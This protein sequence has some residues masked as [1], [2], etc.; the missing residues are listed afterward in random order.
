MISLFTLAV[1]E[2]GEADEL[3]N[4]EE[5]IDINEEEGIAHGF[6]AT[7]R[8]EWVVVYVQHVDKDRDLLAYLAFPDVAE[9]AN[10]EIYLLPRN[11][12]RFLLKLH[13]LIAHAERSIH[14]AMTYWYGDRALELAKGIAAKNLELRFVVLDDKPLNQEVERI[15]MEGGVHVVDDALAEKLYNIPYHVMHHKIIVIDNRTVV[16][17]TAN[18]VDE[19]IE[20]NNN[21]AIVIESRSIASMYALEIE[22]LYNIY[23]S[24]EVERYKHID[25]SYITCA[26]YRDRILIME[27][28]LA[29]VTWKTYDMINKIPQVIYGY[30]GRLNKIGAGRL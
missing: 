26:E 6:A 7:L 16:I 11:W 27:E 1:F 22:K 29:H 30:L 19:D 14:I 15:P 9:I 20:R 13:D 17:S 18:L 23:S 2:P 24:K 8:E 4:L 5:V 25:F 3:P 28:Y 21:T 10:I 12:D